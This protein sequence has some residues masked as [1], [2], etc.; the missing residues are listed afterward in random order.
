MRSLLWPICWTCLFPASR[1]WADFA[2]KA[3]ALVKAHAEEDRFS[4]C[5]LVG[6]SGEIVFQRAYG[7]ADVET[8]TPNETTTVFNVCSL[9][10]QYTGV[11]IFQ[12]VEQGKIR[13]EDSV[14][15]HVD[16]AP[17]AWRP[18]TIRHLLTHSSGVPNLDLANFA[19]GLRQS[20]TPQ[21]LVELLR[22]KPL[23][24]EPGKGWKYGNSGYYILGHIIERISGQTYGDYLTSQIFRRAGMTN[25]S[26]LPSQTNSFRYAKGYVAENGRL[27]RSETVDWTIPFAAGGVFSTVG[28]F[29]AW[30]CALYGHRLLKE[31]S[32]KRLFTPDS[33][34]YNYGWFIR[35]NANGQL[36][37]YHEG[38]NPGFAGFAVRYPNERLY[39][40]VLANI[41]NAPVRQ[42]AEELSELALADL[43][44]PRRTEKKR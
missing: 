8:G 7:L 3:D 27:V 1:C 26:Y 13:L 21:E 14:T 11:S 43:V 12:L 20:Y 9:T 25:A 5:V 39:T 35:T 33:A 18:I 44:Q 29:W 40:V 28:D 37:V 10:K 30:D 19:K 23:I 15:N 34:G 16:R 31:E 17:A 2:G 6:L 36:R 22:N 41:E 42:I 24:F 38:A 4:G 32:L